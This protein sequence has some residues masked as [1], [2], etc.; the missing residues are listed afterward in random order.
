MT[1]AEQVAMFQTLHRKMAEMRQKNKYEIRIIR[2]KNEEETQILREENEQNEDTQNEEKTSA[3]K[4]NPSLLTHRGEI[5]ASLRFN[6]SVHT[7]ILEEEPKG[8]KFTDH[9]M[10]AQ[11]LL[12]GSG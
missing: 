10:E 1:E 6:H 3:L 11:L 12:L 5:H 2:Q 8:H 4:I 9:I 7:V